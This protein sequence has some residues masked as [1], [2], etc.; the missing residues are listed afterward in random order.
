MPTVPDVELVSSW[1]EVDE[2]ALSVKNGLQKAQLAAGVRASLDKA[3]DA[4]L[5]S[6]QVPATA[7]M[8][9]AVGV[10]ANG[11]LVTKPGSGGGGSGA[12]LPD[13]YI[14]DLGKV[15]MAVDSG[16]DDP[17]WGKAFQTPIRFTITQSGTSYTVPLGTYTML[18]QAVANNR[19]IE[20]DTPYG[21]ARYCDDQGTSVNHV[22]VFETFEDIN[23]ILYAH[24]FYIMHTNSVQY[25][26]FNVDNSLIT[27]AGIGAETA[28]IHHTITGAQPEITPVAGHAY[29]C[30]EVATIQITASFASTGDWMV[31]FDTPQNVDCA[32]DLPSA[33]KLAT[34]APSTFARAKHYEINTH[35]SYAVIGEF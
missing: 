17:I 10:D 2:A 24:R 13:L 8:T 1:E 27:P 9:Q 23:E 19:P 35:N 31:E 30:G 11:H 20:A 18:T 22:Y 7:A 3:D 16:E 28:V 34:G 25:M 29:H 26:L 4:I 5:A 33:L 6:V 32:V 14:G 12:D 21:I 15:L